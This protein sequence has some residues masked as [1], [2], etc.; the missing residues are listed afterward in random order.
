[1][2][3][4]DG[5]LFS[6]M[7]KNTHPQLA[8]ESDSFSKSLSFEINESDLTLSVNSVDKKVRKSSRP[9]T[10]GYFWM[11]H[12]LRCLLCLMSDKQD[13]NQSSEKLP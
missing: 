2:S 3:I 1:M 11:K 13:Q 12:P 7:K 10:P 8:S 5:Q 4:F 9:L 6:N